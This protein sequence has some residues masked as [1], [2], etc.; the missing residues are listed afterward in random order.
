M[1]ACQ[2]SLHVIVTHYLILC[3]NSPEV[4]A[5][6]L[7]SFEPDINLPAYEWCLTLILDCLLLIP[8]HHEVAILLCKY[9]MSFILLIY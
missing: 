3:V 9:V 2:P 7:A 5:M 6:E 1:S 8:L 4:V